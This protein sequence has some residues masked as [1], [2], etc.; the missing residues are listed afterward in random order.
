[1]TAAAG[2]AAAKVLAGKAVAGK[3]V[4]ARVR[5]AGGGVKAAAR[6]HTGATAAAAK[7]RARHHPAVLALI[8]QWI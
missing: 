1:M 7:V 8:P 6:Q 4:G 2:E 5:A 3:V